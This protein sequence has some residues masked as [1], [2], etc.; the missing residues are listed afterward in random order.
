M[1]QTKLR[2]LSISE[3][4]THA[5]FWLSYVWLML[6]NQ[7][8][9]I[10]LDSLEGN[11]LNRSDSKLTSFLLSMLCFY[12]FYCFV[13]PRYF[14]GARLKFIIVTLISTLIFTEISNWV[15]NSNN[16]RS[17][18]YW[19]SLGS[20]YFW[21]LSALLIHRKFA[22][23]KRNVTTKEQEIQH[24]KTELAFLKQQIHPHF[25]FNVLNSLYSSSYKYGDRK[26]SEGIGQ[27]AD[28]LRYMLY[29]TQAE[30]VPI[31]EELTYLN[32]YIDLQMLRF[33]EDVKLEY[34][35]NGE[36]YNI[37][38]APML[39]ITLIENAFKHGITP[40]KDN[41]IAIDISYNEQEVTLV[42]TNPTAP[43][44][45]LED[46]VGGVGLVNLRR[47]LHLLYPDSHEFNTDVSNNTFIAELILR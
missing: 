33:S 24:T 35:D 26:T 30:K 25:L 14:N 47:R 4:L 10:S 21:A 37:D 36:G 46:K 18:I 20:Q 34:T 29:E 43:T 8:F 13:I 23:L 45:Q 19:L 27:L 39:F 7:V 41:I 2:L 1:K 6:N 40:E 42:V 9:F 31:K 38:I 22:N 44:S 12:W 5:I 16:T 17:L 32:N 15:N 3:L 11:M 28:L